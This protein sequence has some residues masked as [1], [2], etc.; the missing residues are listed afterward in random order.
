ML[1]N[2]L[3]GK[4]KQVGRGGGLE[5]FFIAFLQKKAGG[6]CQL[7]FIIYFLVLRVHTI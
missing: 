1:A 2:R 7:F 3:I 6:R 5:L 4:R